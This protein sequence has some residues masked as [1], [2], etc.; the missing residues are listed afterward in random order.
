M[1]MG[2]MMMALMTVRL[3]LLM[4][5]TICQ[6]AKRYTWQWVTGAFLPL[7]LQMSL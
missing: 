3:I 6:R 7:C 5:L 2:M 1:G 4:R